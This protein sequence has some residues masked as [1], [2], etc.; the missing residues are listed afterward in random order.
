MPLSFKREVQS[1]NKTMW[2]NIFQITII[3]ILLHAIVVVVELCNLQET[4]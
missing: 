3:W 2:C 4:A 1:T